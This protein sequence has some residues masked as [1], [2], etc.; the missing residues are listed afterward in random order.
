MS[1]LV[2]SLVIA[3]V[4]C[5]WGLLAAETAVAIPGATKIWGSSGKWDNYAEVVARVEAGDVTATAPLDDAAY[6]IC[7]K[8]SG[9]M[10][11]TALLEYANSKRQAWFDS[12]NLGISAYYQL[13][14]FAVRNELTA[15][16]SAAVVSICKAA[17]SIPA[18]AAAAAN[19]LYW[20]YADAQKCDDALL[21]WQPH[22]EPRSLHNLVDLGVR[23]GTVTPERGYI[24]IRDYLYAAPTKLDGATACRLYDLALRLAI[25]AGVTTSDLKNAV[26]NL[27]QLYAGA[28]PGDADWSRFR[29][30]L[31]NQLDAFK[32]AQE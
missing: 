30:K 19:T 31:K 10:S 27:D 17:M 5:G 6:R 32:R 24:A 20:I 18:E 4:V 21:Y 26:S 1:K 13:L 3:I 29:D 28:D 16:H 8:M 25:R 23:N 14:R 12:G 9:G 11:G 22:F 2:L 7:K 15:E